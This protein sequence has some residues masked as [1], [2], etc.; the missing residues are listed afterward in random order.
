MNV[1]F[2]PDWRQGVPYQRLLADALAACDV[3]VTFLS[4]YK[5]VLPL[6]RLVRLQPADLLHLHWP[7]A[8][9]ARQRDRWDPWRRARFRADLLLTARHLPFVVTAHNLQ[10]HNTGNLPYARANYAAAY[11]WARLV[12]AHSSAARDELV[13]AYGVPAGNIHVVPHGDLSV[14]M[15]PPVPQAQARA[16]LGLPDGPLCLIFGTVEPYKGQEEVLA[17]WRRAQPEA[18]LVIVG[19]PS[20]IEYRES[21]RQAAEGL[22]SVTLKFQW[23]SDPELALYLSAA[24]CTVF[25]YRTIFTSGAASLARSWGLP[26]L[27]PS[28]LKTVDLSEPDARVF[29]FT[30][31]ESDFAEKF[32]AALSVPAD[33]ATAAAWRKSIAWERIATLTAAGYREALGLTATT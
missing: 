3:R 30:D 25:N 23:L 17:W 33:H 8:Y 26:I 1:L 9:Y 20:T 2:A 6:A 19:K 7:E 10:E 32:R 31:F 13:S 18:R 14:A 16:Q 15:P 28:R 29:R 24:D 5:R 11:R 21:I 22:S 4:H 12:F 27:I